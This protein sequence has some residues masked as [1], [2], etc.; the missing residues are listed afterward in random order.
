MLAAAVT[1]EFDVVALLV[2]GPRRGAFCLL[3]C[4][5]GTHIGPELGERP[6]CGVAELQAALALELGHEPRGVLVQW[7]ERAGDRRHLLRPRVFEQGRDS[8]VRDIGGKAQPPVP[9]G[10]HQIDEQAVTRAARAA[11]GDRAGERVAHLRATGHTPEQARERLGLVGLERQA[12]HPPDWIPA[13]AGNRAQQLAQTLVVG[14]AQ[15][16]LIVLE[17]CGE[18][19]RGHEH[20][21]IG[22]RGDASGKPDLVDRVERGRPPPTRSF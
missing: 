17:R 3:T 2:R 13:A 7:H 11:T 14:E 15:H 5:A 20:S 21:T 1:A 10:S 12:P 22:I 6:A 9:I 19:S 8:R 18:G 4:V 16:R